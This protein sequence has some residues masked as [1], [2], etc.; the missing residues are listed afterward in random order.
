MK[1][2]MIKLQGSWTGSKHWEGVQGWEGKGN[3]VQGRLGQGEGWAG[4]GEGFGQ[5]L[6]VQEK[7]VQ[8]KN[9]ISR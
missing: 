6:E 8:G 5:V 1:M 7:F 2:A 9:G 3:G 4:P